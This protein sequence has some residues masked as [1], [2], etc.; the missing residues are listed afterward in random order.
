MLL[1]GEN[2]TGASN[3]VSLKHVY[4]MILAAGFGTRLRPLT[5]HVPKP[6]IEVAGQPLIFFALQNMQRAQVSRVVINTHYLPELV[7]QKVKSVSWPFEILFSYEPQ[8]LGT[9]GGIKF[10]A[11]KL[12]GADAILVQNADAIVE[13]DVQ[14]LLSEHFATN[15]LST[16]VLKAVDDPDLYGAIVTDAEDRVR[17]IIGKVGYSGVANQRRM[18][19]GM[20]V[21]DPDIMNWMPQRSE[22]CILRDTLVPA[23]KENAAVYAFEN[24]GFFCDVGTTERLLWANNHFLKDSGKISTCNA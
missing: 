13:T 7:A 1:C 4:G 5:D 17:D 14:M 20:Q 23:I 19:C 12:S 16:M 9:G 2:Q 10:A 8:I 18:F 22:F 21:L 24:S 15:A 3:K 11:S 6:V